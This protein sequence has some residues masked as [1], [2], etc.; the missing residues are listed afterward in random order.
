MKQ[1]QTNGKFD[2]S[3][4]AKNAI[5]IC[6]GLRP[7]ERITI[8]G[9]DECSDII[10]A[11]VAQVEKVGSECS[12]VYLENYCERPCLDLPH[13][14]L[15]DMK[16]SQVSL[17]VAH[18]LPG[19]LNHRS[20]VTRF[21]TVHHM[22]HGHMVNISPEIMMQGM[23]ADFRKV[24][25]L[26]VRLIEKARQTKVIRA[27]TPAG[28]D[29]EAHFSPKLNW[30][31]TS[32]I[33]SE[34][35]WGN[36]PGGEILTSPARIDGVFVVDGVIGDYLCDIYGDLRKTPLTIEIEDS[37]IKSLKCDNELLVKDF[38]DYTAV[39]ENANRVGEFAIGT[40]IGVH[41]IIGNILQDEKIPGIHIAFGDPYWEH[42][43]QD[44]SSLAHIDCVGRE[45][46]IWMDDEMVM[47]GGKFLI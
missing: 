39:D 4:G 35:K 41:D 15:V 21:V 6:L 27:T 46:T 12:V 45:F 38:S 14:I 36:L 19:E 3:A 7:D 11:L 33:I 5:H 43:G 8:I 28:T 24:D 29:I 31:K 23:R 42:T 34:K 32:G 9:G 1:T 18:A 22:R 25:E 17:Y 40:N 37:R 47:N 26:S 2:F 30:L 13:D 16:K 10:N 44:W 20:Q